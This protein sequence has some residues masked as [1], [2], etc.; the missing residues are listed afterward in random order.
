MQHGKHCFGDPLRV[1]FWIGFGADETKIESEPQFSICSPPCP[2]GALEAT[3][4]SDQL[5]HSDHHV[6]STLEPEAPVRPCTMISSVAVLKTKLF[7][8]K[9]ALP[10][11]LPAA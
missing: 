6:V 11:S 1:N 3:L 9:Y 5:I 8:A 4:T 7:V 10:L 2:S